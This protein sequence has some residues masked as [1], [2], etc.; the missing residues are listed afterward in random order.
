MAIV[1]L[2]FLLI[3]GAVSAQ[4]YA[5]PNDAEV[6]TDAPTHP[7]VDVSGTEFWDK[8]TLDTLLKVFEKDGFVNITTVPV[9][10]DE[11]GDSD[12][13][14]KRSAGYFGGGGGCGSYPGVGVRFSSCFTPGR[15]VYQNNHIVH[16]YYRTG[17]YGNCMNYFKALPLVSVHP[18]SGGYSGQLFGG[19]GR[20]YTVNAC[21]SCYGGNSGIGIRCN[22][23]PYNYLSRQFVFTPSVNNIN[24]NNFHGNGV[25]YG[26]YGVRVAAPVAVAAAP[27]A[28]AAAPV[29]VA[30]A[31][32]AVGAGCYGGSCGGYSDGCHGGHC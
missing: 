6:P 2:V 10:G 15:V 19:H 23:A 22:N 7:P 30:A 5:D 25:G 20:T 11:Q 28:V 29:A 21:G 14:K 3:I 26:G 4:P 31:P 32:V 16:N 12:P 9:G 27:V 8:E 17:G 24:V 1:T 18:V 13:R